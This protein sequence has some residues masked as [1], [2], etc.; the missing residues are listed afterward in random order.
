MCCAKSRNL[1]QAMLYLFTDKGVPEVES[2]G[3]G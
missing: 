2:H 3:A 1:A